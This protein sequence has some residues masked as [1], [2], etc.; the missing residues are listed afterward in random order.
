MLRNR[1][2]WCETSTGVNRPYIPKQ[3]RHTIFDSLH[4][5]SHPGIRPS[6]RLVTSKYFWPKMNTDVSEYTKTCLACQRAKINRHTR[7]AL[8]QIKP[9][10]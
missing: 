8:E 2:I 4:G 7:S 1:K 6:R 9:P 5:I 3:L 10:D